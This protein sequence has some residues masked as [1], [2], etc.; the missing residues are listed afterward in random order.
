MPSEQVLG[1]I[2]RRSC[3][4]PVA[5]APAAIASAVTASRRREVRACGRARAEGRDCSQAQATAGCAHCQ[6]HQ[7]GSTATVRSISV[8]GHE[9]VPT[10]RPPEK[11]TGFTLRPVFAFDPAAL[12]SDLETPECGAKAIPEIIA[13]L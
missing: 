6:R 7:G 10:G 3:G 4:E 1:A 5:L 12:R 11:D 13:L 9:P 8:V 2:S